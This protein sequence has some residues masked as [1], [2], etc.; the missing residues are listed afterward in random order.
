MNWRAIV[1]D[2]SKCIVSRIEENVAWREIESEIFIIVSSDD[3]EK[4]F[5]LN[6]TA[7]FLWINCDGK[8][9]VEDLTQLLCL[10]FEVDEA[11]AGKDVMKFIEQMKKLG[12]AIIS[13]S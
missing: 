10:N 5:K 6:R 9:T 12:F 11:E 3:G 1:N 4:V 13:E 2:V 8:R 7:G